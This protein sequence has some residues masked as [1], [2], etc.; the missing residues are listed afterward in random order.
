MIKTGSPS[1]TRSRLEKPSKKR[2][3]YYWDAKLH[4]EY[5]KINRNLMIIQEKII[6][7][8]YSI[9]R[10]LRKRKTSSICATAGKGL[11]IVALTLYIPIIS[12]PPEG[13]TINTQAGGKS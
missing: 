9:Y 3:V 7:S 10:I 12:S 8:K 5:L 6:G 13:I 11:T 4:C 1:A 2:M